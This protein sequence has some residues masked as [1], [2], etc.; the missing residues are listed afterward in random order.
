[1]NKMESITNKNPSNMLLNQHILT[2]K[3]FRSFS[4]TLPITGLCSL[5]VNNNRKSSAEFQLTDWC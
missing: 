3:H 5:R 2:I 1:M 4:N